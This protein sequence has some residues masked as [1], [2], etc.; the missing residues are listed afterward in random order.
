MWRECW[1]S[2]VSLAVLFVVVISAGVV[3]AIHTSW[4]EAVA[5]VLPALMLLAV[6]VVVVNRASRR[7]L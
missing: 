7:R 1:T 4:G 6:A 5:I 3:A 2:N